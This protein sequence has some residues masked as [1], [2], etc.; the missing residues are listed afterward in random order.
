M[1]GKRGRVGCIAACVLVLLCCGE[2]VRTVHPPDRVSVAA[3]GLPRDT[4]YA[5]LVCQSGGVVQNLDWYFP[6]EIGV[7]YTGHPASCIWSYAAGDR[8]P[9]RIDWAAYVRWRDAERYGIVIRRKRGPW[10]VTWFEAAQV[11]VRGRVPL[12]G[13]GQATFDLSRGKMVPL[14]AQ[15]VEHLGLAGVPEDD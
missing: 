13:G 10:E 8:D 14:A 1:Q 6:S 3:T 15:E 5:S 4:Y 12:L 2:L 9:P 11:P 7:P